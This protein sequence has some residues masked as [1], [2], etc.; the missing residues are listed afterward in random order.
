MHH[1]NT[2][3]QIVD[4]TDIQTGSTIRSNFNNGSFEGQLVIKPESTIGLS[5]SN[6]GGSNEV[7][8]GLGKWHLVRNKRVEFTTTFLF[9]VKF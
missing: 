7:G 9:L 8:E 2:G 4:K 3:H 1:F 6:H 5:S